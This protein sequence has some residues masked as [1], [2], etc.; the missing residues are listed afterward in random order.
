MELVRPLISRSSREGGAASTS[1]S[2]EPH[3]PLL[4]PSGAVHSK[5]AYN[6]RC[7]DLIK[8]FIQ[9]AANSELPEQ[10]VVLKRR[11]RAGEIGVTAIPRGIEAALITRA[12]GCGFDRWLACGAGSSSQPLN[13]QTPSRRFRLI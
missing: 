6:N 3:E 7:I 10:L 1:L 11:Q 12:P 8:P 5:S 4:V 2:V 9:F 13:A